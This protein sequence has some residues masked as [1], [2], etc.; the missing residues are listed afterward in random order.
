MGDTSY[1]V[2]EKFGEVADWHTPDVELMNKESAAEDA[3][4]KEAEERR[5]PYLTA[6]GVVLFKN[7]YMLK[8]FFEFVDFCT[9]H[10]KEWQVLKYSLRDPDLTQRELAVLCH[11]TA[12]TVNRYLKNI[13]TVIDIKSCRFKEKLNKEK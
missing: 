1:E 10:P 12:T 11:V 8:H 5:K 7:S 6:P 9:E 13:K 4:R 3:R 2:I